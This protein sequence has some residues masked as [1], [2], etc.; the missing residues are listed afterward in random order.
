MKTLS[1]IRGAALLCYRNHPEITNYCYVGTEGISG[2][3]FVQTQ[4]LY[5][6]E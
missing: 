3:F 5:G 1:G 4:K 6:I 2:M